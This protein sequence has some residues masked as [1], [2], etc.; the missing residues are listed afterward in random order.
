V[1]IEPRELQTARTLLV[2]ALCRVAHGPN[3]W[4]DLETFLADL[5]AATGEETVN[6]YWS[7]YTWM[8]AFALSRDKARISADAPRR[9]AFWL[10]TEGAWMANALLSTLVHLGLVERGS[11]GPSPEEHPC[12]RLTRLGQAVFGAPELAGVESKQ[13]PK[14]LTVQPNHEIVVY[15]D[16]ADAGAV[17][18]LAQMARRSP[19][20]GGRVQTFALTRDSVYEALESG[21][22]LEQMR[23]FLV[24][25]SRTG[26][27]ANVAQSLTEWGRK[28]EALVVRTEVALGVFPPGGPSPFPD[29]PKARP[30]GDGCMLLPKTAARGFHRGLVVDHQ[31]FPRPLW[32]VDEEGQVSVMDEADSVTLARLGQFADPSAAGWKITAA[33]VRRAR[34]WGIP[35]EQLLGW[36]Q[37]HLANALSPLVETALRNWS[38]PAGVFLGNLRMLQ[39]PQPQ[40]CAMMRTSQRFQALLLGHIP[41]DW[42]IIRAEKSEELEQLLKELGFAVSSSYRLPPSMEGGATVAGPR[43]RTSG[44][45]SRK[46]SPA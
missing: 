21:L 24:E 46:G 30:V 1:R 37:D 26:L 18:P 36:L 27:P 43:R 39:V 31:A 11:A 3:A 34:E 32:R 6:F 9:R 45:R 13:E 42:F 41:P 17:W 5:W 40:A 2:W 4:L 15:L 22:T 44:R 29:S 23:H 35:A 20:A 25:H 7:S 8:P 19:S 10:D 33:S 38:S 28:R 14:F 16:S 12:F